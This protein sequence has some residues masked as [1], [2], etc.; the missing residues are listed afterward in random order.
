MEFKSLQF[1]R[2]TTAKAGAYTG[3]GGELV[4]DSGDWTLNVHDGVTK[5]GK[6]LNE[7]AA[8]VATPEIL[9]PIEG[10]ASVPA[11]VT[12]QTSAFSGNGVHAASRFQFA[13]D[14]SFETILHDSMRVTDSLTS[15]AL[16]ATSDTLPA[17]ALTYVRAWH[18][19][20]TAGKSAWSE[21]VS[22]T[23]AAA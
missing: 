5:G 8:V 2:G 14:T 18:E 1:K 7:S 4:V 12:V 11:D 22:F 21:V 20:D 6:S 15:Y 16:S 19:S 13:S 23:V 9:S 10:A 17:G 3:P